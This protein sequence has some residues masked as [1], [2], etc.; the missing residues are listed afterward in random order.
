MFL[1]FVSSAELAFTQEYEWVSASLQ[2]HFLL[3]TLYTAFRDAF[4]VLV[5]KMSE[6][7]KKAVTQGWCLPWSGGQACAAVSGSIIG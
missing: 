7:S 6:H 4:V 5:R 3:K 2:Q 1:S